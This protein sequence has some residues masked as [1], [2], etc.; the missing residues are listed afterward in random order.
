MVRGSG[1]ESPYM[2]NQGLLPPNDVGSAYEDLL[3]A[4]RAAVEN[5]NLNISIP[6]RPVRNCFMQTAEQDIAMIEESLYLKGW[7]C[8]R[9]SGAKRLDV[10][11]KA[12]EKFS[13]NSWL[14]V[15]STVYVNYFIVSDSTADLVQAL[16]YDF[17]DGGQ[18]CHP[19]FHVHLSNEPIP[20][21]DLRNT[22]FD[23]D[24]QLPDPPNQCWVTTKIPTPDMTL[25]SVLYS[26]AADHLEEPIFRQFATN[27]HSIQARLPILSFDALRESFLESMQ[28]FKSPHWFAHMAMTT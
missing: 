18:S 12:L 24:V 28:H 25:A 4:F 27:V 6:T 3:E 23:L 21:A 8:R 17:V 2:T 16:H 15:N 14:L 5:A 11:I 9:L 13:R 20:E 1:L 19:Y 26:L 7:P 10:V 22:G